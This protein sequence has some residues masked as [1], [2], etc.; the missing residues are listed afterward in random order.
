MKKWAMR[1]L[2]ILLILNFSHLN[3]FAED[4]KIIIMG[5]KVPDIKFKHTS[6]VHKGMD[7]IYKDTLAYFKPSKRDIVIKK[8]KKFI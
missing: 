8:I 5:Q 2:L 4:G 7:V 1:V 3:T 6:G